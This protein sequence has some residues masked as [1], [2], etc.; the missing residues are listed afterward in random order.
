MQFD[1]SGKLA[2]IRVVWD[3]DD[4]YSM[5]ISADRNLDSDGDGK[6]TKAELAKLQGFDMHWVPPTYPGDTHIS[7]GKTKVVL[8]PPF[9]WKTEVLSGRIISISERR[10]DPPLDPA[11]GEILVRAYDP[12][13]YTAYT[14]VG[15]TATAGRKDCKTRI[16]HADRN[17]A[18]AKLAK[19][20][21]KFNGNVTASEAAFPPVGEAYADKVY[22]TCA[23]PS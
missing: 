18:D 3:Y 5:S 19:M 21:Q 22:L 13:Y 15:T 2:T 10:L 17:A 6:L 9:D 16:Q 23:D 4:F 11:Q 7:Q 14:I 12:T 8:S 20:L 1:R